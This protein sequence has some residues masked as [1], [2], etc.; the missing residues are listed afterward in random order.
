MK[1]RGFFGAFAGLIAAPVAAKAIESIPEQLELHPVAANPLPL[2]ED[3]PFGSEGEYFSAVATVNAGFYEATVTIA[4]DV[5]DD[6]PRRRAG[7]RKVV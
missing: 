5:G 2:P 1:R 7:K 3:A 6:Y 4:S